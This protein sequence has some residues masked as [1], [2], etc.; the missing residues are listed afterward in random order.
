MQRR[1]A[2]EGPALSCL[3]ARLCVLSPWMLRGVPL[4]YA[5]R[6]AGLLP[7]ACRPCRESPHQPARVLPLQGDAG[8]RLR[9]GPTSPGRLPIQASAEGKDAAPPRAAGSHCQKKSK[10]VS[11]AYSKG[12]IS[13]CRW[14]ARPMRASSRP[15]TSFTLSTVCWGGSPCVTRAS[16]MGSSSTTIFACRRSAA[17]LLP[18]WGRRRLPRRSPCCPGLCLP[19]RTMQSLGRLKRTR[20]TLRGP[21]LPQLRSIVRSGVATVSAPKQ[22]RFALM[23][24]SFEAPTPSGAR[25]WEDGPLLWPSGAR[26]SAALTKHSALPP[27]PS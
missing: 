13:Q 4:P 5:C 22:K 19:T 27:R 10:S 6:I 3:L 2:Y 21:K 26:P 16:T 23:N 20:S 8:V 12:T 1:P 9:G 14:P 18:T 15:T 24:I 11:E 7:S 25:F 17:S